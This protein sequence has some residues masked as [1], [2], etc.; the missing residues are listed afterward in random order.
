M[1]PGQ[2]PPT[3]FQPHARVTRNIANVPCLHAVFGHNPEL[4]ANSSVAHWS[5]PRFSGLATNSLKERI[6]WRCNAKRK[7][8]LDRR[9]EKILLQQV[10][11]P[12]FHLCAC[13]YLKRL[14]TLVLHCVR[15]L[16][17]FPVQGETGPEARESVAFWLLSDKFGGQVE[18]M[19]DGFSCRSS[20]INS[21]AGTG[22]ELDCGRPNRSCRFFQT[23]C[24]RSDRID[25]LDRSA[26]KFRRT[27]CLR[28]AAD[29][30]M[31]RVA[32][33]DFRDVSQ[34]GVAKMLL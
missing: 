15:L 9:I 14:T 32:L 8:N 3:Q 6:P 25:V 33:E 19:L 27:P 24:F 26:Q 4:I 31:R 21:T 29:G 1:P 30:A 13:T 28:N 20:Q 10:N 5:T 34:A 16:R 17:C 12:I 23:S 22:H 11:N 2:N 18:K 7:Q